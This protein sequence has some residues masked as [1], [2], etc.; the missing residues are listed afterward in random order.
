[1]VAT[2]GK[3]SL[4]ELTLIISVLLEVALFGLDELK[5]FGGV[6]Q[7]LLP[8]FMV[9]FGT[10]WR[11]LP[12]LLDRFGRWL[13]FLVCCLTVSDFFL[14]LSVV[15]GQKSSLMVDY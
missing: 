11:C 14:A 6:T 4:V 8:T 9:Q 15:C 5:D 7:L 13:A 2:K 10:L 1:M 12:S 3:I